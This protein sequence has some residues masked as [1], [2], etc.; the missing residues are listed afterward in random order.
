M[1][2]DIKTESQLIMERNQKVVREVEEFISYFS[3]AKESFLHGNCFWFSTILSQRFRPWYVCHIYYNQIDN[4]FATAIHG[5]LF[6]ASGLL[7]DGWSDD[8]K[9][10]RW[11]KFE[12]A[13]PI[14]T[15]RIYR[16]CAY[17]MTPEQWENL[18]FGQRSGAVHHASYLSSI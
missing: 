5:F 4:H 12:E 3:E 18:S 10:I 2:D 7:P 8:T 6:D 13:E 14:E 16:D 11:D 15:R 1:P 17:H 9:W